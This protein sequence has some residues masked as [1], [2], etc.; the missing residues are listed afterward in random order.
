MRPDVPPDVR[1]VGDA[2][3]LLELADDLCVVVVVAEARG[4]ARAREGGE[5]HLA[6]RGQTGRL[7][8]PERRVRRERE[9]R[10]QL[11]EEPVHDLHGL[12]GVIDGDM[13]VE[14]EDQ[15]TPRDVLELVDEGAVAVTRR[16]PLALEVAERVRAGGADAQ[17][18]TLGDGGHVLAELAQ[19]ALHVAGGAA[20]GRGDLEHGLHELRPDLRLELVAGH[21]CEHGV[22]VL[23]EVE[24]LGVEEHVL[25]LHTERVRVAFPNLCSRTLPPAAKPSPVM[26]EG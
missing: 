20:D 16:D 23:H 9:E 5:H 25:L 10:R 8:A 17:L 24:A 13:D 15:L 4:R 12:V 2:P 21:R 11:D 3:G 22:D 1:V 26:L 18:L 6:R 7:A 14:T 19:L